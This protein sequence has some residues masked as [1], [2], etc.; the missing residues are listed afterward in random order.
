MLNAVFVP[1]ACSKL[2]AVCPGSVVVNWVV[3]H[4]DGTAA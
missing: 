2:Y 4:A 3:W 1:V